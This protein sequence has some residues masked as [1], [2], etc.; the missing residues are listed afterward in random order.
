MLRREALNPAASRRG[1]EKLA[2]LFK[3]VAGGRTLSGLTAQ[4]PD[5]YSSDSSLPTP[6]SHPHP[7]LQ[8]AKI[9]LF[10]AELDTTNRL[11]RVC[12]VFQSSS[13][14]SEP[15]RA[16]RPLPCSPRLQ[17]PFFPPGSPPP[18]PFP[19][20]SLS[21]FT[22]PP[23]TRMN[24]H[25]HP[26]VCYIDRKFLVPAPGRD[27]ISLLTSLLLLARRQRARRG[28]G[29]QSRGSSPDKLSTQPSAL[30][31]SPFP[32]C[33]PALPESPFSFANTPHPQA[34]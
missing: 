2:G 12:P 24:T 1:C 19:Q 34:F 18:H 29:G 13:L 9:T 26:R 5:N 30:P 14:G 17:L 33:F 22:H 31:L 32:I 8:V 15:S 27:A 20:I 10:G 6:H 28:R 23:P 7:L 16:C 3:G 11:W 21:F 25:H 4:L